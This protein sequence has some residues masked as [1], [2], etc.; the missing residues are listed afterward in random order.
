MSMY[1]D[2]EMRKH[3]QLVKDTFDWPPPPQA[4]CSK[5]WKKEFF[6]VDRVLK[7]GA[8]KYKADGWLDPDGHGT[9]HKSMHDSMFHHLAQSYAGIRNDNESKLDH[10]LHVACRALMLYTRHKRLINNPKDKE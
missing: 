5:F 3:D 1:S 8:E 9:S 6:D 4:I 2:E 10:L 7:M